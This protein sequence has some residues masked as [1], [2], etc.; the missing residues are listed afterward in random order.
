[1][2]GNRQKWYQNFLNLVWACRMGLTVVTC[3]IF[4]S[5]RRG[6]G[7]H[8]GGGGLHTAWYSQSFSVQ[9]GITQGTSIQW[10]SPQYTDTLT[11]IALW[12]T[13]LQLNNRNTAMS[14]YTFFGEGCSVFLRNL[15]FRSK[16]VW[17]TFNKFLQA[18]SHHVYILDPQELELDIRVE[19]LVL[20]ALSRCPVRHCVDLQ[21]TMLIN[22]C[23]ILMPPTLNAMLLCIRKL[24][25]FITQWF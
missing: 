14:C 13:N 5:D 19:V 12:V 17:R 1:M 2:S 3:N 4:T 11:R 9:W 25:R 22:T 16:T 15:S 20:V 8:T 18:C 23:K 10:P 24:L 6:E 7:S 21:Y